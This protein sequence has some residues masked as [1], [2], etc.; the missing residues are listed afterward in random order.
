V[1]TGLRHDGRETLAGRVFLWVGFLPGGP[2]LASAKLA[3]KNPSG[4]FNDRK[5]I[6]VSAH[7]P[8]PRAVRRA[9][10]AIATG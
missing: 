3:K 7:R 5:R 2:V 4:V 9:P 8:L 6:A 10:E 1:E